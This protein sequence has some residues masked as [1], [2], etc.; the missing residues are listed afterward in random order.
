VYVYE[1]ATRGS[2]VC[3]GKGLAA[4]VPEA[5]WR[6]TRGRITIQLSEPGVSAREP[7]AYRALVRLEN[8]EFMSGAVRV[9]QSQ[10]I[11][12][13]AIVGIPPRRASWH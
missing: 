13:S 4:Y 12:L 2:P 7:Q 3:G 5:M 11:A 8:A 10:P 1:R 6:P 9:R